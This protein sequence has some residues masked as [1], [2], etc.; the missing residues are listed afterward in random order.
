MQG[1]V[2]ADAGETEGILQTRWVEFT[3][4]FLFVNAH[5]TA[6][7]GYLLVEVE[8]RHSNVP[9]AAICV[10]ARARVR[11]RCVYLPLR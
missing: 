10:C 4:E 11:A 3:G 9:D 7:G 8:L 2:S 5:T 6:R 1:F